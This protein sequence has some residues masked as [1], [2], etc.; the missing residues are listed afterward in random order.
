[1][2]DMIITMGVTILKTAIK[3]PAFQKQ[4]QKQLLEV[5]ADIQV[6]FGLTPPTNPTGL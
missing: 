3:N 4:F 5:A 6:S 1:M 2:E